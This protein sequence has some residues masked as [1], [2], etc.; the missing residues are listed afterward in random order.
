MCPKL[1]AWRN[2]YAFCTYLVSQYY[3]TISSAIA[4][5]SDGDRIIVHPGVYN[6]NVVL[7]KSVSLIGAGLCH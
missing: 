3:S 7:N 6:E 2:S 1:S 4:G 5:S